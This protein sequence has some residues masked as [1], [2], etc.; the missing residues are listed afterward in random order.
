[1]KKDIITSK[2][3]TLLVPSKLSNL[4]ASLI[5]QRKFSSLNSIMWDEF[6]MSGHFEITGLENFIA[7]M[8]QLENYQSTMHQIMNVQGEWK[9]NLYS[10]ETYCV[11]SHMFDKDNKPFKLDMGIV[12]SDV[13]EVREGTAKFISRVFSLKWQ[14][15]DLLDAPE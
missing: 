9:E 12:Y 3:S 5:D 7:A 15:T 10:G 6:S 1:M 4:Y 8:Q 13:I 14:K 11:A 2:L